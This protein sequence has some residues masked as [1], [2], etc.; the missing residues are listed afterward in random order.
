M[1]RRDFPKTPRKLFLMPFW[2]RI[3]FDFLIF[4][5]QHSGIWRYPTPARGD[6]ETMRFRDKLYWLYKTTNPVRRATRA[7]GLEHY[8]DH[9]D[10]GAAYLPFE[11]RLRAAPHLSF[12]E[13]AFDAV[14]GCEPQA[15]RDAHSTAR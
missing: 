3:L 8:F 6:L 2:K 15:P 9:D 4:L 5:A 11:F 1:K 13:E 14:V 12:D 10:H 7:S